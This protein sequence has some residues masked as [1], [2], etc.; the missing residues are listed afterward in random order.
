[1]NENLMSEKVGDQILKAYHNGNMQ[2]VDKIL[3]E[4]GVK[5]KNGG[6]HKKDQILKMYSE[7]NLSRDEIAKRLDLSEFYVSQVIA[8]IEEEINEKFQRA[9]VYSINLLEKFFDNKIAKYDRLA[10]KYI[11]KIS[12]KYEISLY[13]AYKSLW[14]YNSPYF[15]QEGEKIWKGGKKDVYLRDNIG[16]SALCCYCDLPVYQQDYALHHSDGYGFNHY[17]NVFG[18]GVA[19]HKRCHKKED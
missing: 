13:E 18:S 3:S 9:Q 16:A 7:E 2:Q 5:Y 19:V 10:K 15:N 12:E 1:M 6:G 14:D 17:D 4:N 8:P 11:Y